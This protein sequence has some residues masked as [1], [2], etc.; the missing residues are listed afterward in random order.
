MGGG[1]KGLFLLDGQPLLAHVIACIAPQTSA[2]VL[3]GNGDAS[4]FRHL[5]LAIVPDTIAGFPG[6]LA[7]IL[8]GLTWANEFHP[9]HV[10]F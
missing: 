3:N 9:A 4:R 2:L 8:A 6:P 5:G 10:I 1:D 7:G